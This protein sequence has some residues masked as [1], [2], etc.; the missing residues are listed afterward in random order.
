[1]DHISI[2]SR[3]RKDAVAANISFL[4]LIRLRS[5]SIPG[6]R[7][8][9]EYYEQSLSAMILG[10]FETW[11][12]LPFTAVFWNREVCSM[13]AKLHC[14]S[15]S[16]LTMHVLIYIHIHQ[17]VLLIQNIAHWREMIF[18][19][20]FSFLPVWV[21]SRCSDFRIHLS[22]SRG[23]GLTNVWTIC[24]FLLSAFAFLEWFSPWLPSPRHGLL[25]VD[26]P[27]CNDR[28][29]TQKILVVQLFCLKRSV[30]NL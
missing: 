22:P 2:F 12:S 7:K 10:I 4:E 3:L 5:L 8:G 20:S 30:C 15:A 9:L 29:M 1:M 14:A 13:T 16:C 19:R 11:C 24:T 25:S 18:L 23:R 27:Q 28:V 17:P 21:I 6:E 26:A